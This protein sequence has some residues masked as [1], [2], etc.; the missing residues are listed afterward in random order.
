MKID[1]SGKTAIVTGAGHGLGRAIAQGL[2]ARGANVW[3][4]D[5]NEAGLQETANGKMS[6][7]VLD[8]SKRDTVAG[9]VNDVV[10]KDGRLDVLVNNAGGVAGQVGRPIEAI[11]LD[12]WRV[13]FEINVNGAFWFSQAAAPAMKK[14]GIGRIV[15]ISSGAG[16]GVSLTGIQA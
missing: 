8:V 16:L 14:A 10:A 2:A 4:C 12:E 9:F 3:A 15:N 1:F 6:V 13:I 5:L 7:R 11:T